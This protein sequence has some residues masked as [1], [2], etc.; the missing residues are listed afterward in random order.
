M[1]GVYDREL[2]QVVAVAIGL[3]ASGLVWV[4]RGGACQVI[5]YDTAQWQPS[6]MPVTH[7]VWRGTLGHKGG[8][9]LDLSQAFARKDALTGEK[10]DIYSAEQIQSL[11]LGI[12]QIGKLQMYG[13]NGIHQVLVANGGEYAAGSI[14]TA[15]GPWDHLGALLVSNAGGA[16]AG[17]R[18]LRDSQR[19]QPCDPLDALACDFLITANS[20]ETLAALKKCFAESRN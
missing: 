5:A 4:S 8:I 9:H 12:L 2:S 13:S 10:Y 18:I 19:I 17:Y 14:G 16:I 20:Q 6:A 1:V 3:P 7:R 11:I 15:G